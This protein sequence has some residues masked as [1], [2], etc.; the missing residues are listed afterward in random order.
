MERMIKPQGGGGGSPT[1]AP[2]A[3]RALRNP[4]PLF[5]PAGPGAAESPEY[6]PA[7]GFAAAPGAAAERPQREEAAAAEVRR[8]GGESALLTGAGER[9]SRDEEAAEEGAQQ[10]LERAEQRERAGL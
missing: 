2:D 8:A 10:K 7:V 6:S 3:K 1:Q 4:S 9:R 5:P